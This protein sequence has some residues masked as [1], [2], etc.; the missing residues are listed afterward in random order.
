[1]ENIFD[2]ERYPIADSEHP[3][4]V[5]LIN[6]TKEELESIGCAVIPGFHQTR[7]PSENECR[8]RKEIGRDSLDFRPEQSVFHQR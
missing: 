5:D 2:L 7:I 1:M 3:L 8:S 6:I 4:T